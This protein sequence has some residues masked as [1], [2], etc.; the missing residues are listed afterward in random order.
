MQ[1]VQL[2]NFKLTNHSL[3]KSML[4]DFAGNDWSTKQL[5]GEPFA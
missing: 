4:H 3:Q 1:I 2:V 5:Q